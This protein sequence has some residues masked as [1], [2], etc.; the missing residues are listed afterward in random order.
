MQA[1]HTYIV[2]T[3]YGVAKSQRA[4]RSFFR[5][6]QN[7]SSGCGNEHRLESRLRRDLAVT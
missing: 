5:N 6:R 2:K 4:L 7:G 1:G 3:F